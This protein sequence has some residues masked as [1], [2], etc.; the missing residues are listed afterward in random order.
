MNNIENIS[1]RSRRSYKSSPSNNN[2]EGGMFCSSKH[3]LSKSKKKLK[4][5]REI[6]IERDASKIK[7]ERER[8]VEVLRDRELDK[9]MRDQLVKNTLKNRKIDTEIYDEDFKHTYPYERFGYINSDRFKSVIDFDK[10]RT[11][12]LNI[13]LDQDS[14]DYKEICSTKPKLKKK[15]RFMAYLSTLNK[16]NTSDYIDDHTWANPSLLCESYPEKPYI[17]YDSTTGKYCCVDRGNSPNLL[18]YKYY[19]ESLLSRFDRIIP[20][21]RDSKYGRYEDYLTS[22]QKKIDILLSEASKNNTI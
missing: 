2:L 17:N 13:T 16:N 20:E 15:V 9:L 4:K 18:D 22:K 6:E 3:C 11:L 7:K 14:L 12:A 8:V 21:I 10:D 1:Y 19:V 5:K